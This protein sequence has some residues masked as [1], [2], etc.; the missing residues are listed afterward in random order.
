V[1][2]DWVD[3]GSGKPG[4]VVGPA[5]LHARELL[6]LVGSRRRPHAGEGWEARLGRLGGIRPMANRKLEK[7]LFNF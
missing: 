6:G 4:K 7:R 2:A 5:G 3:N 1:V